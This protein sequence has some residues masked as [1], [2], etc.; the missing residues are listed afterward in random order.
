MRNLTFSTLNQASQIVLRPI[1]VRGQKS[2]DYRM[3]FS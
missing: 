2:L 1:P 3:I